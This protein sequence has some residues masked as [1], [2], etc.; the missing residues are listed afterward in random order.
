MDPE[1]NEVKCPRCGAENAEKAEWCYLCEYDF[2]EGAGTGETSPPRDFAGVPASPADPS[3]GI[4]PPAAPTQ[5]VPPLS[6]QFPKT[7]PMGAYPPGFPTAPTGKRVSTNKIAL[8]L[9]IALTVIAAGLLA[10]FIMRGKTYTITVPPPPGYTEASGNMIDEARKSLEGGGKGIGLDEVFIDASETNFVFVMHQ[11]VP[12]TDA[13]SGEDPDEMERYFY[14]SKDEWTEAFAS[15]ILEAGQEFAP[16]LERYEVI[17]MASGDA[18]LHMTTSLGIQ[19]YSFTVDTLWIIK[20]KSAFTIVV[21]GLDP[22]GEE[23]VEF[24]SENVTFK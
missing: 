22:N 23:I 12:F 10:F 1:V 13:P 11:N 9:V 16:E 14:D 7:Q 4:P 19:Q 5:A 17:R 20:E 6:P 15:G 24:L 3:G 18:A 2:A 8:V 21:E